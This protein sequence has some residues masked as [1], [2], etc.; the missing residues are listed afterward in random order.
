MPGQDVRTIR[1]ALGLTVP[2]LSTVLGVHPST[3]HRWEAS[4]PYPVAI[5]G[6]PWNV[7]AALRQRVIVGQTDPNLVRSK[8]QEVSDQLVVGGALLALA[9]LIMFVANEN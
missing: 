1:E 2:K 7:L 5:E 9:V 8:G 6:V 3:I 4:G